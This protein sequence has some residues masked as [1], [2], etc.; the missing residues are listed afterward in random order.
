MRAD[1]ETLSF[2][3]RKWKEQQHREEQEKKAEKMRLK[4]AKLAAQS[5]ATEGPAST[6]LGA[7]RPPSNA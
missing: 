2:E 1:I 4:E 6:N 5:S 3:W 7:M